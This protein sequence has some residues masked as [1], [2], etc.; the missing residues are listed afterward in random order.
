MSLNKS[1]I[2]GKCP[3][4]VALKAQLKDREKKLE[5]INEGLER[6]TKVVIA[7][8]PGEMGCDDS[9]YRGR[10]SGLFFVRD[11]ILKGGE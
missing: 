2:S 7:A 5:A 4:C 1:V 11:R 6:E 8:T 3:G 9:Y 10:L